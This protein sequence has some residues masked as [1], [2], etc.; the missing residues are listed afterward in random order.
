MTTDELCLE[1]VRRELVQVDFKN[2]LV[3]ALRFAGKQLGCLN[4]YGY[5][6]CTLHLDGMR[7]QVKVHR[8]IWIAKHGIPPIGLMP[9]HENRTRT[10]NRIDNLRLVD[11]KGN[12]ENRRTY[13]GEHNPSA[14]ITR[15]VADRIRLR[16]AVLRSY[17]K[18]SLEFSVSPSL[19]AKIVRKE[20][21]W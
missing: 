21:W 10:D 18:V 9:D 3:F 11:A 6:V 8:L 12:A 1:V 4:H 13:K 19:V 5:L 17:P 15:D 20:L 16:H 14:K 2:G 7:K